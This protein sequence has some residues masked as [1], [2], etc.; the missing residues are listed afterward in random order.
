MKTNHD[1]EAVQYLE[2]AIVHEIVDSLKAVYFYDLAAIYCYRLKKWQQA[3]DYAYESVRLKKDFGKAYLLM[4]DCYA[5]SVNLNGQPK[6]EDKAIFWAALDKFS[7]AITYDPLLKEIAGQK[8]KYY[9]RMIPT[10]E[11]LFMNGFKEGEPYQLGGWI[12]EKT[13]V[14]ARNN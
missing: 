1:T 7:A 4:G 11:E 3:R 9:S 8:I 6:F 5:L 13:T 2:K 10:K 14:R 12:N